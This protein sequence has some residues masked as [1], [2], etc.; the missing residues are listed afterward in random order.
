MNISKS[1]ILSSAFLSFTTLAGAASVSYNNTFTLDIPTQTKTSAPVVTEFKVTGVFL[2]NAILS[3][4][5]DITNG[6]ITSADMKV[7]GINETFT[8]DHNGN[9]D[10]S[11]HNGVNVWQNVD[12]SADGNVLSLDLLLA[13]GVTDLKNYAGGQLCDASHNCGTQS[14]YYLPEHD[15]DPLLK[16][17]AAAPEPTAMSLI[18]AGLGA[19]GLAFRRRSVKK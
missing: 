10:F 3:G 14:S 12:L 16:S 6:Q 17:G 19:L 5:F 13:P 11:T 8:L 15:N 4:Y 7:S 9:G 1:I 18:G 2:D